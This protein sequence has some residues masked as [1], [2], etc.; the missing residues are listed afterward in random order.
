MKEKKVI[1]I[2]TTRKDPLNAGQSRLNLKYT[3]LLMKGNY[4]PIIIPVGVEIAT[5]VNLI[6]GVVLSGGRDVHPMYYHENVTFAQPSDIERDHFELELYKA[7]KDAGKPILGICRGFQLLLVAEGFKLAQDLE[8]CTPAWLNHHQDIER[9]FP[10]HYVD[11]DLTKQF[12][13]YQNTRH[14][15]ERKIDLGKYSSNSLLDVFTKEHMTNSLHHQGIHIFDFVEQ[16]KLTN[17]NVQILGMTEDGV[18][19]AIKVTGY[20]STIIGVQFHIEE[21]K[22]IELLKRV[23][24]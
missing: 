23:F 15:T 3:E 11:F 6:D 2:T 4:V 5:I 18:I 1:G 7:M 9:P 21:H 16:F 19:E 22:N 10:S 17:K 12:F 13:R 8:E 20:K 14:G 24:E